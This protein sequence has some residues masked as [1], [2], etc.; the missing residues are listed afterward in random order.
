MKIKPVVQAL[1]IALIL[2]ACMPAVKVIPTEALI[3]PPTPTSTKVYQASTPLSEEIFDMDLSADGTKLAI[4]A[5]TG[6][7]IYDTETLN[8][9]VF[10]DFR[11]L[12]Y[13]NYKGIEPSGAI[14][15]SPDG[16]TIAISGKFP[17]TPVNLWDLRTSQ[18]L[19]GIYDISPAYRVTKIQF[20][21]DGKSIFIR[22]NYGWTMR[23]EQA[24]ANFALHALEYSNSLK[25][26]KVFSTDICQTIPMGFVRFTDN[27]EFLIFVQIMGPQYWVTTVDIAPTATSNEIVYDNFDAL[28]D[29]SP[30]GEIYAFMSSQ[31]N[32][33]VT[34]LIDSKTSQTL[35]VIPYKVELLDND[36]NHFLVRDFLSTN[37]EWKLWKN[38]N[39][40]CNFEGLTGDYHKFSANG[41]ILATTTIE[42]DVIIW[43]V[44]DCSRKNV[45]Q[46]S[47]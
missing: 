13:G 4:Y 2:S 36:I 12:Y 10:Q 20:S 22:S 32:L 5:N 37:D 33:R 44:S 23:C 24:D 16:N 27:N 31:E 14:A 41:K 43:N 39:V 47:N 45:L 17:D 1:L 38:G 9:T 35:A 6:I 40:A 29:V 28:Y 3:H 19:V 21:P 25:A 15:F 7:Y 34:K 8:K 11:N 26:T 46:F 42:M 18:Y 30:N